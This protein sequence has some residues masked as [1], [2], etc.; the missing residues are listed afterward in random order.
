MYRATVR[1]GQPL[2]RVR[3]CNPSTAL[4]RR[5]NTVEVTVNDV[6]EVLLLSY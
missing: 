2:K 6:H 3:A 1:S 4:K 5:A